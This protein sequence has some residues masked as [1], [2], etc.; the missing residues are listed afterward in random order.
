[1]PMAKKKCGFFT[2][3]VALFVIFLTFHHWNVLM[4]QY[5]KPDG[6]RILNTKKK[7]FLKAVFRFLLI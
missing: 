6:I 1:M 5:I 4:L 3:F 2:V 7:G